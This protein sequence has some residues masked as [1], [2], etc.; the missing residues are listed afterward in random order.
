M[1]DLKKILKEIDPSWSGERLKD[2]EPI[3][4]SPVDPLRD[5][6]QNLSSQD[7]MAALLDIALEDEHPEVILAALEA[8]T[9]TQGIDK[10]A[11]RM[12]LSTN[13][14]NR[15]LSGENP[16]YLGTFLNLVKALGICSHVKT[17]RTT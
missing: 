16:M 3:Q 13:A 7:G 6:A 8:I 12:G 17:A 5:A 1:S 14:I 10:V 11:Q 4:L 9:R 2:I 15:T